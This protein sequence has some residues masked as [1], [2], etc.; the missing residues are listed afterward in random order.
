VLAAGVVFVGLFGLVVGSFLNVVISRVPLRLPVT[1]S[2]ACPGCGAR[3][4]WRDNIPVLSWLLLRGRC[5]ECAMAISVRYPA[6]ELLTGGLF[7]LLAARFRGSATLPAML[8]LVAG[9]IALAFCD[10]DG[11]VLPKRILYPTALL[12]SAALTSAAAAAGDWRRLGIAGACAAVA[13][14]AFLAGHLVSPE[15]LGFGDVRLAPLIAGPLGWLGVGYAVLA[16][17]LG[18]FLG[19]GT[20][21]ALIA[22]GRRGRRDPLPFGAFLAVGAVI[23]VAM[24]A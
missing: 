11:L 5:R 18:A 4:G 19:A 1:F 20:G 23:A 24:A 16:F 9:L 14:G 7:V 13:F 10:L 3:I 12:V 21:L 15:G 8:V 2:S 6:V 22:V 17:A